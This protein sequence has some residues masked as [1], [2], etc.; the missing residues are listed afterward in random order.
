MNAQPI[1]LQLIKQLEETEAKLKEAVEVIGEAWGVL[2]FYGEIDNYIPFLDETTGE[3]YTC[4]DK[5]QIARDF[6]S[7][8]KE[9]LLNQMVQE[10]QEMWLYDEPKKEG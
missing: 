6:L 5:G 9:G 1:F 8:H 2:L 4:A 10:N 3:T 7:K